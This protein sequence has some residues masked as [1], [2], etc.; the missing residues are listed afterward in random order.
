MSTIADGAPSV[1]TDIE[2]LYKNFSFGQ[3]FPVAD[4]EALRA[5]MREA[6]DELALEQL[7]EVLPPLFNLLWRDRSEPIVERYLTR[8]VDGGL[9]PFV[10]LV[11]APHDG[12]RIVFFTAEINYKLYR[13]AL[14]L[15]RNGFRV[16]LVSLVDYGQTMRDS[17]NAAFDACLA[18]PFNL[19]LLRI[20]LSR[21]RPDILHV[22]CNMFA[23]AMARTVIEAKGDAL[24]VCELGDITTVYAEPEVLA[25]VTPMDKVELDYAMERYLCHHADG[26]LHQYSTDVE[27]ELRDRHGALPQAMQM[28]P[29]PCPEFIH[30]ESARHSQS[31]GIIRCVF[32]GNTPPIAPTHPKE[33]YPSRTIIDTAETLC[34]QGIGVDIVLDPSKPLD[35][36]APNFAAWRELGERYP[37][38]RIMNGVPP[39]QISEAICRHDFGLLHNS[40]DWSV[41]RCRRSK[42]LLQTA[43]KFF[44]YLEA[45][46]PILVDPEFAYMAEM[47]SEHGIGLVLTKDELRNAAAHIAAFDHAAAVE[48]IRR[49]N[50]QHNMAREIHRLIA[51]YDRLGNDAAEGLRAAV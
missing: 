18:L 11:N 45:G 1:G 49:Y 6:A 38:F 50:E 3:Q 32:P 44:T 26:L 7:M 23:Y 13:E 10:D 31:D 34:A 21:L 5:V 15:K 2:A 9:S 17:F 8:Y 30:Y 28:Q 36:T 16:F 12:K 29:F 43:N 48:N 27:E 4:E 24:V 46:L 19:T 35:A 51:F 22:H 14:Y 39:D 41:L 40:I 47:V 37:H 25:M 42:M 33:V 20:L